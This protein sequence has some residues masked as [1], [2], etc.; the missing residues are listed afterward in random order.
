LGNFVGPDR[1]KND[2]GPVQE[3]FKTPRPQSDATKKVADV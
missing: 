1:L 2:D 3:A